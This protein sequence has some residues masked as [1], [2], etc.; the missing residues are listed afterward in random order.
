MRARISPR[1]DVAVWYARR[2]ERCWLPGWAGQNTYKLMLPTQ[3]AAPRRSAWEARR[4]PRAR[5]E[6]RHEDAIT[7]P[8]DVESK[9]P[10]VPWRSRNVTIE[11]HTPHPV[12]V[13]QANSRSRSFSRK[14]WSGISSSSQRHGQMLPDPIVH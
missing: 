3:C 2:H 14:W 7:C 11:P 1:Y 9:T 10:R 8:L 6:A 5:R 12:R 4:V 13:Q